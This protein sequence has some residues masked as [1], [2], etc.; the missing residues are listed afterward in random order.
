[1]TAGDAQQ[2]ALQTILAKEA[3]RDVLLRYSFGMD[4]R[5]HEVLASAF[6]P[7]A[8]LEYGMFKG[9]GQ[10]FARFILPWFSQEGM[11]V[12]S[13]FLGNALIRVEQDKAWAETYFNAFHCAP[14][15]NGKMRDVF[16]CGRYHD[17]FERR[18]DEWRIAHRRLHFDWFREYQ[19]TGDWTV[20]SY[21]VTT[22]SATIGTPSEPAW[23]PFRS[24]LL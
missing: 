18:D 16:V 8:P 24:H 13:H 10:E 22:A 4:R 11:Q 23:E 7:G 20:G 6:W 12:T 2:S 15:P 17:S 14:D 5:D 9:S 21:G 1:M 3:I 19:D